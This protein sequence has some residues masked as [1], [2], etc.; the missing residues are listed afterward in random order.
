[1]PD[2]V[3]VASLGH[4]SGD[5]QLAHMIGCILI[6]DIQS[7]C[8]VFDRKLGIAAQQ[9]ED[10]DA[11]MIGK[12]FYYSLHFP[13]LH[14]K[15]LKPF[16]SFAKHWNVYIQRHNDCMS[17]A[18]ETAALFLFAEVDFFGS[19]TELSCKPVLCRILITQLIDE[20]FFQSESTRH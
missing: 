10:L 6:P 16:Q 8:D 17:C 1:M 2:A 5:R 4:E 11:P 20:A 3:P 15:I 7:I 14:S 12:A 13:I 18:W 9:V 19:D